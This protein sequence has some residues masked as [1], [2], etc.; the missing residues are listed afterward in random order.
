MIDTHCH[1]D[2]FPDPEA[3]VAECEGKRT[4]VVAV[5]NLPSHYRMALPHLRGI[6]FIKPALGFHPLCAEEN[7]GE[8]AEFESLAKAAD[9]IGEIGMDFSREGKASRRTQERAFDLI[10]EAISDRQRFVTL[11]SR[12]AEKEVLDALTRYKIEKAVFHWYSGSEK[13]VEDILSAGHLLSFNPAMVRSEKG[14]RIVEMTPLDRI[15]IESDGPFVKIGRRAA[16]PSD[17]DTVYERVAEIQKISLSKLSSAVQSNFS[18]VCS[19]Q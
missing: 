3:L 4:T 12:R 14:Q 11:H 18:R 6:C 19:D 5:T 2:Q 7:Q 15:L 9:F 10:L 17:L 16:K 8:L 13:R 1:V